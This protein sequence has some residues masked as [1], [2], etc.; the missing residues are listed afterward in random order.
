MVGSVTG[1]Y[2]DAD[3]DDLTPAGKCRENGCIDGP[4]GSDGGRVN[5]VIVCP[6]VST[7]DNVYITFGGGGLLIAD[8]T[9]TPM[10]I[11][12]EYG[13]Q[14]I[15]GAGC[16]G[17]QTGDQM[18]VNAGVSASGA[19]ATQSTFTLYTIDDTAFESPQPENSPEPAVVYADNDAGDGNGANTNTLGNLDGSPLP[20]ETG[21]LPGV[22][23]RRDSH[24][25]TATLDGSYVHTVDRIQNVVEVI[26]T[27]DNARFTYDL[28]S[29]NGLGQGV[30]ACAASSVT[31]DPALPTN[32]PAPDLMDTTP[33]G[34]YLV[35]AL[36]GPTPVS[37]THAAQ[38]SCPGV[39]I[40][41]LTA[42]GRLGRLAAV[43]RS[44][45]VLDNTSVAAPGGHLYTGSEHSDVHG[46]SVRVRVEDAG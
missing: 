32:D 20:N 22:T 14:V 46:A 40:I 3:L 13:Q 34:R 15:N 39:G 36:R 4:D 2:E 33:D 9:T 10:S 23:T 16:G 21:Q 18:W 31:D 35:V 24:G 42:N 41:E 28:I 25:M 7:N 1:S 37:V 17:E 8:L 11:V 38:G 30:G 29:K 45:N 26:R 5:N 12:G 19:G 43:L 44:T 27:S 6:I